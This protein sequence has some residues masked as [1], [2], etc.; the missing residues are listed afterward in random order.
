MTEPSNHVNG[1]GGESADAPGD[2]RELSG[3][4][5]PVP[6]MPLSP[7]AVMRRSSSKGM[8]GSVSLQEVSVGSW[9]PVQIRTESPLPPGLSMH[10]SVT[11]G[12]SLFVFG[13]YSGQYRVKDFYEFNFTT[14]LWSL[15]RGRGVAPTPRDRH[16]AAVAGNAM[17]IFGGHDGSSR[18]GDTHRFDFAS[19]R[20][21]QVLIPGSSGIDAPTPRHSCSLAVYMDHLFMF[22]GFDG[23]YRNDVHVLDLAT[24]KWSKFAATG[25]PPSPRYRSSFNVCGD[26][27]VV[28]AGHDGTRHL[29]DIYALNPQTATWA[30]IYASGLMPIPRD[31]H[32]VVT[33]GQSLVVFGGSSGSAMNDLHELN[34][35][36][37]SWVPLFPGGTAPEPRFCHSMVLADDAKLVV[38]GGYDGVS[39]RNDLLQL[40]INV[41]RVGQRVDV[42]K[43]TILHDLGGLV[44][45][46]RFSDVQF[47]VEDK[48]VPA[49]K[50]ILFRIAHFSKLFADNDKDSAHSSFTIENVKHSTFVNLLRYIYTDSVDI[51]KHGELVELFEVADKFGIDRLKAVC[52]N[53]MLDC[54][55]NNNAASLFSSADKHNAAHLRALAFNYIISN[56]DEVSV[57]PDF[58]EMGR[59]RVDLVFEV[60]KRRGA[61]LANKF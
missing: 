49:H 16:A 2:G 35:Q 42:P 17:Y 12:N 3:T 23:N 29:N 34:M 32:T 50:L 7:L 27:L 18:L 11:W 51:V 20:W 52:Q 41:G 5:S 40:N 21:S 22:G 43:S 57:T 37:L 59:N 15:V 9:E 6:F 25:H 47:T 39:R 31:S 8:N 58:E 53:A 4:T 1:N 60:L 28:I 54:I 36:T 61:M 44:G 38:F 14:K 48:V 33:Y 10:V 26:Q 13:G 19:Q 55:D 56:F 46:D 24:H 45:N 30:R